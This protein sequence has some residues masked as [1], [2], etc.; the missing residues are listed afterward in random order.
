MRGVLRQDFTGVLVATVV[1]VL[2]VGVRDATFLQVGQLAQVLNQAA[3]VGVLA[4]RS[5]VLPGMVEYG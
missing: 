5:N 3:V 1:L 2:V 4:Y